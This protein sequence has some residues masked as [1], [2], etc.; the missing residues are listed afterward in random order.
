MGKK[1]LA[2]A[3][4]DYIEK[5]KGK[6]TLAKA[7]DKRENYKRSSAEEDFGKVGN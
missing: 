5:P 7:S 2:Q 3:I 1:N 4:G 6:P